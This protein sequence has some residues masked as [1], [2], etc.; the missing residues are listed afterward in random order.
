[1]SCDVSCSNHSTHDA[2]AGV[3]HCFQCLNNKMQAG[4]CSLPGS[5]E[6]IWNAREAEVSNAEGLEKHALILKS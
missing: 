4:A 3:W 5:V 2:P 6:A 1:M